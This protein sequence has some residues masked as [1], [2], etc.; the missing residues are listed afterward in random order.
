MGA[1][2]KWK[3]YLLYFK[4]KR[5]DRGRLSLNILR[6]VC[7]FLPSPDLLIDITERYIR[8]FNFQTGTWKQPR[9]HAHIQANRLSSWV[10]LEDGLMFCCG[11][12]GHTGYSSHR[13]LKEVYIFAHDG[14]V[15]Q[16][17]NM[18]GARGTHGVLAYN[19]AVYVFGG[20]I[21]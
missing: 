19:K 16:M 3:V 7:S 12:A 13:G 20:C 15:K 6:E 11:G 18:R 2:D 9:P 14:A 8:S 1:L 21:F 4:Y 17:T 10:V 5:G